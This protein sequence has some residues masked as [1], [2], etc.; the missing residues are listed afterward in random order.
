MDWG[1]AE[2]LNID[3][4]HA[5]D[6]IDDLGFALDQIDMKIVDE[7][8]RKHRHEAVLADRKRREDSRAA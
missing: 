5:S 6:L 3:K 1:S 2:I 4:E 7:W 8:F